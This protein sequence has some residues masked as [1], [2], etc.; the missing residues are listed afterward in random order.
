MSNIGSSKIAEM[1]VGST[2]ISQAYLGSTK[3]YEVA[4]PV[5][6]EFETFYF[7]SYCQQAKNVSTSTNTN[8]RYY[9]KGVA[10]ESA[11]SDNPTR[12]GIVNLESNF[13]TFKGVHAT[14]VY[15]PSNWTT[16]QMQI[17]FTQD[18]ANALIGDNGLQLEFVFKLESTGSIGAYSNYARYIPVNMGYLPKVMSYGS[19]FNY[20]SSTGALDGS[21]ISTITRF[22]GNTNGFTFQTS[23]KYIFLP[24]NSTLG[25]TPHHLVIT[26]SKKNQFIRIWLDGVLSINTS[27]NIADSYSTILGKVG[28]ALQGWQMANVKNLIITQIG[29]RE[30]IWKDAT[31]YIPPSQAYLAVA[32]Y[33]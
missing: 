22:T 16:Y 23:R 6:P 11:Y 27:I 14:S 25:T 28:G 21:P 24:S 2:K 30:A 9:E 12:L 17:P 13:G 5:P 1:Y 7:L 31:N 29:V 19:G 26:V 10:K 4:A 20:S 33:F 32:D 15:S 3:V 18:M 8:I